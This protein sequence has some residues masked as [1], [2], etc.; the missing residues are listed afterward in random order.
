M[1][2]LERTIHEDFQGL[3]L[4]IEQGIL[5][6]S[7]SASKE[8]GTDFRAG[9]VRCSVRVYERYSMMGGNRVSMTVTLFQGGA[10]QPVQLSAITAGGSQGVFVKLVGWGENSFLGKL[11]QLL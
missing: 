5:G 7:I 2:K 3:L 6:G 10:G 1:A 9:D 8:D 11:E 4:R